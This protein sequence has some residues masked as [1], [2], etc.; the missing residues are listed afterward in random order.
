MAIVDDTGVEGNEF[1]MLS[2][3]LLQ[4]TPNVFFTHQNVTINIIDDDGETF[5]VMILTHFM[6]ACHLL[7]FWRLDL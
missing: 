6:C 3:T 7:Q 1:L 2:L 5:I 4:G